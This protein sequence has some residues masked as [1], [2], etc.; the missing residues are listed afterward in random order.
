MLIVLKC[1][2]VCSTWIPLEFDVEWKTISITVSVRHGNNLRSKWANKALVKYVS[3][4]F[5][6]YGRSRYDLNSFIVYTIILIRLKYIYTLNALK[7]TRFSLPVIVMLKWR[8][9][10]N[11]FIYSV[12]FLLLFT[13]FTFRLLKSL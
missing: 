12:V 13:C 7:W 6:F 4:A 1:V 9:L 3:L 8:F 2:C 10:R 11:I 5:Y